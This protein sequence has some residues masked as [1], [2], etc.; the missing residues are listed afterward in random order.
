MAS[1]S[2]APGGRRIIQ[3]V[4]GDGKRRSIRLGK[5]PQ[6]TAEEIKVKVELLNAAAISNLPLDAETA[7]WLAGI[8]DDLAG[9]L[10]VVGLMPARTKPEATALSTF[11]DTYV[12][13]RAKGKPNSVKNL[14]VAKKRLTAFYGDELDLREVSPGRADDWVLYLRQ[15]GYARA[16]IGRSIKYAK[17]F[18]RAAVRDRIIPENPFDDIKPPGQTNEARKYFVS[19]EVVGKVLDACPDVEWRL[20]VALS[21]FGGLRCPSEHF[22]LKW[23]EIDWDRSRFLVHAPKTE[24]H[25]DGGD[26]WVP[27]FP[28]LRPY[29]EQAFELAEEGAEYV[30]AG[31]RDTNKNLRTRFL[32]IIKRAGIKPWPKPFQNCRATR[33][34]ELAATYP[35]HVVCAWIGN[36]ERIASKHYLQI[37]EDYFD[38]AAGEAMQNPVQHDTAQAR[39]DPRDGNE[40]N[41]ELAPTR[42]LAAQCDVTRNVLLR[43]EGFEPPTLGSED[44]C[45]VQLSYGRLVAYLEC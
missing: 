36:T 26:R 33:E 15:E 11:L 23:V 20:I 40:R 6:R 41:S 42:D 19:R 7:R 44:R 5:V 32:R 45:S 22:G 8:G 17:Q 3:F 18:F 4:A 2:S 25:E 28:E 13:K 43:P 21:R 16:T 14:K 12:A 10:A 31:H 34:T 35:I 1:I 38:Q 29:L 39:T 37:T 9:K 27:I 24:H 30:I